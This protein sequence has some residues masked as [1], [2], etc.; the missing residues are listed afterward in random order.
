MEPELGMEP[1]YSEVKYRFSSWHLNCTANACPC[2]KTF[3]GAICGWTGMLPWQKISCCCSFCLGHY[4]S[5][6]WQKTHAWFLHLVSGTEP[7]KLKISWV[8][9]VQGV[10]FFKYWVLDP[11]Y[12]TES[13]IPWNSLDDKSTFVLV[14]WLLLDFWVDPGYWKDQAMSCS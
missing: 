10:F 9:Q 6:L 12:D 1:R 8:I 13:L 5:V 7:L 14:R 3:V 4:D 2:A 11:H